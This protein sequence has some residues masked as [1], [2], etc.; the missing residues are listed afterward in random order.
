MKNHRWGGYLL[1]TR[2]S[3]IK[4]RG[5]AAQISTASTVLSA[6]VLG[7]SVST[8][9]CLIGAIAGIALVESSDKLNY[10]MLKKIVASWVV[11]LPAA[12]FI[13]IAVF[14]FISV[15]SLGSQ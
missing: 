6:S 5:F 2:S 1:I 14:A 4:T 13:G 15:I 9:H 8:T 7:L 12:A 3:W 10:S 11:T